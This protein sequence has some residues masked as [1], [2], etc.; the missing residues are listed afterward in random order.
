LAALTI[1]QQ[2]EE[3]HPETSGKFTLIS[4]CKKA[5]LNAFRPGPIGVKDATQDEFDIILSIRS[6]QE[7]L[8][9]TIKPEWTPGHPSAADPRG[10]QVRNSAAHALAVERLHN[11]EKLGFDEDYL[12][13]PVVTVLHNGEAVT[14]GLPQLVAAE[15]HY[16]ALKLKQIKDNKW[17]ETVFQDIDWTSYHKAMLDLPRPQRLSISKLSHGLWNTNE[18]NNKYYHQAG[19]CPLCTALE[20]QAR[21]FSCPYQV[22]NETRAEALATLRQTLQ[23]AQIPPPLLLLLIKILSSP[24]GHAP[25]NFEYHSLYNEQLQVGWHNLHCGHLS[26]KW[27]EALLEFLPATAKR[28]QEKATTWGK[29]VILALWKYSQAQWKARNLVV[30]GKTVLQ[31][32]SKKIRLLKQRVKEF[33]SMY[34]NDPHAIPAS[35]SCLFNEP[36][37]IIL[38]SPSQKLQSWLQSI[39]E[40]IATQSHRDTMTNQPERELMRKFFLPKPKISDPFPVKHIS[41]KSRVKPTAPITSVMR[42]QPPPGN[43]FGPCLNRAVVH[44]IALQLVVTSPFLPWYSRH[45]LNH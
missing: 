23:K 21:V 12:S 39:T 37:L 40:A 44:T 7:T 29:K 18:Q 6:L 16:E 14:R 31:E 45:R 20:T 36:L 9:T 28:H 1:I 19:S 24:T 43:H 32:E 42:K 38:Q 41:L 2:V 25:P 27:R 26:K 35:R 15:C 5:L 17:S 10:E 22:A 33:Y 3:R 30:H 11:E 13:P 34:E 4:D 8:R